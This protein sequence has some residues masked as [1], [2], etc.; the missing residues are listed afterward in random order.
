MAIAAHCPA[1]SSLGDGGRVKGGQVPRVALRREE[2]HPV[3]R[4]FRWGEL[5]KIATSVGPRALAAAHLAAHWS[6]SPASRHTCIEAVLHI[7]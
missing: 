2:A 7:I 5:A 3:R 4:P 1:G 6:A